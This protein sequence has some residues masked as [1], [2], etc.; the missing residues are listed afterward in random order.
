MCVAGT[1]GMPCPAGRLLVAKQVRYSKSA[2]AIGVLCSEGC[3]HAVH[4]AT[5]LLFIEISVLF[6]VD[7]GVLRCLPRRLDR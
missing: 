4:E 1:A 5:S 3:L 2:S 7:V 6:V